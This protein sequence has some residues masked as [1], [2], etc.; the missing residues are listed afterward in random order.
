MPS[1]LY[2]TSDKAYKLYTACDGGMVAV[3][4]LLENI[5]NSRIKYSDKRNYYKTFH[6]HSSILQL[7]EYTTQ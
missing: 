7:K 4:S 1:M 3:K 5:V 6:S 2:N